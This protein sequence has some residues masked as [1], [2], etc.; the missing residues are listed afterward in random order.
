MVGTWGHAGTRC[1]IKKGWVNE[2]KEGDAF[3]YFQPEFGQ[4][5]VVVQWDDEEDPDLHKAAGLE[6][7]RV[8]DE[9]W[10]EINEG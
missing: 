6:I 2:G 3:C 9:H 4:Y 7:L 5:W 10:Q 1:R 8:G